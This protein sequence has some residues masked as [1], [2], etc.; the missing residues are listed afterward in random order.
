M[1]PTGHEKRVARQRIA[2]TIPRHVG[3]RPSSEHIAFQFHGVSFSIWS[4]DTV[5]FC[6]WFITY[7]DA[8]RRN[9]KKMERET[10]KRKS[11]EPDTDRQLSIYLFSSF[12]TIF[13]MDSMRSAWELKEW[14]THNCNWADY[15]WRTWRSLPKQLKRNCADKRAMRFEHII[16]WKLNSRVVCFY[17][18]SNPR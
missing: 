2:I 1:A 11:T 6:V 9:W 13:N 16:N 4:H 17:G 5:S 12:S 14:L 3:R 10:M 8:F 15:A 18:A 7:T